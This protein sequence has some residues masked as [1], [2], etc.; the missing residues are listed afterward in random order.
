[1][2]YLGRVAVSMVG[3]GAFLL[4]GCAAV[5]G[6]D[7][8]APD[9]PK[10]RTDAKAISDRLPKLGGFERVRWEI[11]ASNGGSRDIGPTD[12]NA[13]G[14]AWL[15]D[16]RVTQLLAAAGKWIPEGPSDVPAG[17]DPMLNTTAD[18]VHSEEFDKYVTSGSYSGKF[19]LNKK[20]HAVYFDVI[21]PPPP[22]SAAPSVG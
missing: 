12:Y 8:A 5:G 14:I 7:A 4:T 13:R 20:E 9:A 16:D 22:K 21:N 17:M 3:A 15:T 6:S 19:F 10:V 1:M 18:W 11:L 2:K